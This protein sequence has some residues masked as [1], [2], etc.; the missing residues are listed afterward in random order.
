[1]LFICRADATGRHSGPRRA[2]DEVREILENEAGEIR[3]VGEVRPEVGD[4][5]EVVI[6]GETRRNGHRNVQNRP[7]RP[8]RQPSIEYLGEVRTQNRDDRPL[9]PQRQSSIEYLGQ[10]AGRPQSGT[11]PQRNR[12]NVNRRTGPQRQ[13]SVEC[14]GEVN[15][16]ASGSGGRRRQST[17]RPGS[18]RR[19]NVACDDGTSLTLGSSVRRGQHSPRHSSQ[20][21]P[22]TSTGTGGNRRRP[23]P[24][25]SD[26]EDED[27]TTTYVVNL[28]V[29][30]VH[31]L[32]I[33]FL[34]ICFL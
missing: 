19:Q 11:A 33:A 9:G 14:L 28:P 32:T 21:R 17:R 5:D 20:P 1:M 4:D 10:V 24:V 18:P 34:L 7:Q 22:G 30:R 12:P 23:R 15:S 29:L 27:D 16:G 8:Q 3:V 13:P 6:V 31:N 25:S 2:Y 26:D